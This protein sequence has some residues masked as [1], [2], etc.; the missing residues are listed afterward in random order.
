MIF[1]MEDELETPKPKP[2]G[3][4]KPKPAAVAKPVEVEVTPE[5]VE[6]VEVVAEPVAEVIEVVTEP[7]APA[8][9]PTVF[10]VVSGSDRDDVALHNIVFENVHAKKSL[11]V[12]HLQR[13]LNE[14]GFVEAYLDRDGWYGERTRSAVHEFQAMKGLPVGNLDLATLV[15]IFEGDTNVR[16]LP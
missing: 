6:V 4:A 15:A 8:V 11:S 5:P 16:V 13:R 7:A 2:A 3:K 9:P 1:G 14:W 10:A 12:H